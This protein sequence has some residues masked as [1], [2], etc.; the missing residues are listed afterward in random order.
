MPREHDTPLDAG[1]WLPWRFFLY[2]LSGVFTVRVVALAALGVGA[3]ILATWVLLGLGAGQVGRAL[4][5]NAAAAMTRGASLSEP[6]E[7]A[8]H[9]FDG[10]T[11]Y[12][13]SVARPL[14]MSV[15]IP[16]T[17]QERVTLAAIGLARFSVWALFGGAIARIA[18][19]HMTLRTPPTF[20][21]A[22]R[23]AL[24]NRLVL[25]APPLVMIAIGGALL[26]PLLLH[27]W[28]MGVPWL[29][30]LSALTL[31][32]AILLAVAAGVVLVVLA[33]AWPLM[34][35]TAATERPDPFDAVSTPYA[36][37]TQRPVRLAA[38]TLVAL[39]VATPVGVLVELV[40]GGALHATSAALGL[41]P[42]DAA[43]THLAAWRIAGFWQELLLAAPMV[44][45]AA[46]FWF[47]SVAM[48]LL[49]R[50]DVDETQA[51]E[52]YEAPRAADENA[53]PAPA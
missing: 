15:T 4:E 3:S 8:V 6:L 19:H 45:Y 31:P 38:Y 35:A 49:L 12:W 53:P 13:R 18:A 39:L 47:A 41:P 33:L 28:L 44:F 1:D 25:I 46:Y 50:R 26:L 7:L 9:A 11:R 14:W 43:G 24:S 17:A 42:A 22:L 30:L 10:P 5:D 48:Y 16:A 32:V 51:D 2:A 52:I 29:N 27:A 20:T 21:H 37:V 36:Y 23:S 34:W 40:T